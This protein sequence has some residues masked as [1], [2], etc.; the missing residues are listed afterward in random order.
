[1]NWRHTTALLSLAVFL[2]ICAYDIV[3]KAVGGKGATVSE[4]F[5]AA[6]VSNPILFALLGG[7]VVHLCG[8]TAR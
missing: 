5:Y 2:F 8:W 4:V 3:A 6:G 1:M 7:L